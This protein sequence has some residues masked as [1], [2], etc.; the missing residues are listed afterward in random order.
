MNW[1]SS[2]WRLKSKGVGAVLDPLSTVRRFRYDY[3]VK[4]ESRHFPSELLN[5][6]LRRSN[7]GLLFALI[8]FVDRVAKLLRARAFNFDEDY[9]FIFETDQVNLVVST[10]I[11]PCD[12]LAALLF[13]EFRCAR[14][15]A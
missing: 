15:E 3:H 14:L 7:E 8:D 6:A 11:V 10:T 4:S 12:N 1:V 5:E 2:R 13:E 9:D